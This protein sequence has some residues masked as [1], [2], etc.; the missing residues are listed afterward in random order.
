MNAVVGSLRIDLGWN[1]KEVAVGVVDTQRTLAGFAR[2]VARQFAE[3]EKRVRRVGVVMSAGITAPLAVLGTTS[4]KTA[5]TFES[6][7]A[8]VHAA[9]RGI[10]PDKLEALSD[11]ARRLGPEVGRSATEAAEGIETL[12][13]TGL[14][15]DQILRGAAASTLRL[16]AANDAE[17]TPAAEAVTDIMQQFGRVTSDLPRIVNLVTGALDVSKLSFEDYQQAISQAG[18]VA[19]AAG[20]E[21][22]DFNTAIAATAPLFASGSDAGTSFKTFIQRLVPQSADAERVMKQL[23]LSFFDATGRMKSM[24]EIAEELRRAMGGLS[25]KSQNEAMTILFGSDAMRTAIGLMRQGKKGFEELQATI[26]KTDAGEK[27]AIQLTGLEASATRMGAAFEGVKISLGQAGLLTVMTAITGGITAMLSGFANLPPVFHTVAVTIGL[28]AAALGPLILAVLTIGRLALPLFI[29]RLGLLGVALVAII[30]PIGALAALLV[31]L[32]VALTGAS[33]AV[34]LF[35]GAMARVLGPLGLLLTVLAVLYY[36]LHQQVTATAEAV[37]ASNALTTAVGAYEEAA[38]AAAA[39]TG[40]AR[41]QALAAAAAKR[42]EAKQ[43]IANTRALLAEAR[44]RLASARA[45]YAESLVAARQQEFTGGE[46]ANAGYFGADLFKHSPGRQARTEEANIAELTKSLGAA[47]KSF[48]QAEAV[49]AAAAAA[50]A[51][52]QTIDF[53]KPDTERNTRTKKSDAEDL[54]R[55]REELRLEQLLAVARARGDIEGE[56]AIQRQVDLERRRQEYI[57][58]GLSKTVARAAAERDMADLQAARAE[59]LEVE[60]DLEEKRMDLAAARVREDNILAQKRED[61]LFVAERIVFWRNQELSIVEAQGKAE[62]ELAQ[63]QAARLEVRERA[64]AAAERQRDLELAQLRGD[65]SRTIRRLKRADDLES[66]SREI[67]EREGISPE[68]AREKAEAQLS[69][70]DRAKLQGDF[71]QTFRDGVRAAM[72]GDLKEFVKN[73]FTERLSKS[74]ED[75]LNSVADLL[76]KLFQNAMN[77]GTDGKGGGFDFLSALSSVGQIVGMASGKGGVLS[78]KDAANASMKGNIPGF[79]TG[80]SFEIGGKSGIDSNLIQFWGTKGE[81]V[82][83]RRPGA[84]SDRERLMVVPSPYFDLVV[85]SRAEGVAAPLAAHAQQAGSA[86]ARRRIAKRQS[87]VFP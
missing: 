48:G 50:G 16:A 56:R 19:G 46:G 53:G 87:R 82:D 25:E 21:F 11:L 15:A 76:F 28:V 29:G 24:A 8:D 55:R 20:T 74:L 12:A 37:A 60:N 1:A 63:M 43:V 2:E 78:G 22:E 61:E 70:E 38:L 51:G 30:N 33:S 42:E 17:L 6:A 9:L 73:W 26:G 67:A 81:I 45:R 36:A 4:T 31:R 32:A 39:A 77:Q 27:L 34:S 18:G 40:E 80:G 14:T 13:L 65:S 75:A 59:G 54:A 49:L 7:M 64:I 35:A 85:D 86:D 62:S 84:G 66:R 58:A 83:V 23:G 41:K 5:A 71:R 3:I 72:D 47:E 79:A 57:D 68:N 44:V 69:E 10:S 52:T